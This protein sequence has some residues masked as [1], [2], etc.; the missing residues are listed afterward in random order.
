MKLKITLAF[1][2]IVLVTATSAMAWDSFSSSFSSRSRIRS[3]GFSQRVNIR[4]RSNF[5]SFAVPSFCAPSIAIQAQPIV[6]Q[7]VVDVDVPVLAF[8]RQR[9]VIQQQ[10]VP[11][12]FQQVVPHCGGSSGCNIW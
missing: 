11:Q 6:Q 7:Q 9:F 3:R 12:V 4:Q 8:Q 5:Q 1:V 2:I 10:V